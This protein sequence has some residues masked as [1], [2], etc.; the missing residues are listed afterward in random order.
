MHSPPQP[1]VAL[2]PDEKSL[3]DCIGQLLCPL[4]RNNEIN[5]SFDYALDVQKAG[6]VFI[7]TQPEYQDKKCIFFIP[8][9]SYTLRS[10]SYFD[11]F[12]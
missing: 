3:D 2:T 12:K 10:L 8:S 9:N 7:Q 4:L 6:S 1:N 5:E 11:S